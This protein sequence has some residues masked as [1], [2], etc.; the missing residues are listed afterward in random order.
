MVQKTHPLLMKLCL[1][2][3]RAEKNS[4]DA[5]AFIYQFHIRVGVLSQLLVEH[6]SDGLTPSAP[7]I[8]PLHVAPQTS[9]LSLRGSTYNL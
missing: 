2:G 1:L 4:E 9:H 6:Q 7:V 5:S 3:R 8:S